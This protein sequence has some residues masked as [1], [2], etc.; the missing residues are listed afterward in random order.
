MQPS[1][2]IGERWPSGGDYNTRRIEQFFSRNLRAM[3]AATC[4]IAERVQRRPQ[5]ADVSVR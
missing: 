2:S 4:S 5:Q 3:S 1:V